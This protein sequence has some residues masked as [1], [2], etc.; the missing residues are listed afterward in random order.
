MRLDR[1]TSRHHKASKKGELYLND[2]SLPPI[3]INVHRSIRATNSQQSLFLA[4]TRYRINTSRYVVASGYRGLWTRLVTYRIENNAL[5]PLLL[6]S[7][8]YDR[9]AGW[10]FDDPVRDRHSPH[11]VLPSSA[12]SR[13]CTCLPTGRI[14][15]GGYQVDCTI[16]EIVG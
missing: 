14:N 12:R 5:E 13:A 15:S 6:L 2:F 9:H 16:D 3:T 7:L 11:R 1:S 10:P 4:I 8:H